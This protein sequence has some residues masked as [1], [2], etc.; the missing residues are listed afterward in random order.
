MHPSDTDSAPDIRSHLSAARLPAMPQVLLQLVDHCQ[1]DEMS[2]AEVAELVAKDVALTAKIFDLANNSSSSHRTNQPASLQQ[3]LN[4]LG[5]DMVRTLLIRESIAQVFD[6]PS[7]SNDID[8][9]GFWKHS[10]TA[11][12]AA[13][14]IAAKMGYPH[15]EE[16]YIAG[17]LHDVGRLALLMTDPKE[18]MSNIPAGDDENLCAAERRTLHITHPQA[19]ACLVARWELDSFLADSVLY[20]HE[21]VNR[22]E[23]A[24]PLIRIGFLAHQLSG[25]E[26][27]ARALEALGSLCGI[28]SAVL[29]LIRGRA[30][31]R[32]EKAAVRLGIDLAG[33]D[34]MLA[35]ATR[36]A[37][38]R[39]PAR[40]R[41]S[42]K[43][44]DL[45]VASEA[46][47]S[48]ARQEG[49]P[50]LLETVTQSA[51]LL[52]D[53]EDASLFL[54]DN[55]GHALIG[56]PVGP[57]RRRLAEFSIPL[58]GGGTIAAAAQQARLSYISHDD[59][60]LGVAEEQLLRILGTEHLV[61]VPL[62][63]AGR[64]HGVVIGGVSSSQL[65]AL[66]QREGF[67][68]AFGT[69]VA[70][71]LKTV[72]SQRDE[73]SRE[74]TE[75]K[76]KYREAARRAAHEANN[77]LSI[78]KNYLSVL[79]RKLAKQEPIS[80]EISILNE[81]INRVGQIINKLGDLQPAAREGTTEVNRVVNE[82]VR[83]FR[84]TEY[85]PP[86]VR[87]MARTQDQPLVV[88]GDADLLKQ[89]LVNLMKN[90]VEAL[91]GAGEIAIGT[92]GLVNR[93]GLLYV[94]LWIKD[95]GPGISP[96]VMANLFF[97]TRSTKGEGHR[98]I[99]LSIVHGLVKQL[100]GFITCRSDKNGTSF[101]ILLP[102][103]AGP[104]PAARPHFRNP[105]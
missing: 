36:P 23:K 95:T 31:V 44:R 25:E 52:F 33:T 65:P 104:S 100:Q 78:I 97:P 27:D 40:E 14:M 54:I 55:K 32:V 103:G 19:G 62:V 86:A 29:A 13:Q 30:A 101:E 45:V 61:C 35:P 84:D 26:Q 8:L 69:Q 96:D 42:A 38:T 87:I 47:R 93:D 53:F 17:L 94:E 43:V 21:P 102:S 12:V 10:L 50:K 85:I 77:P 3:A 80:G 7:Q 89:I 2:M 79:D 56:A 76:E 4:A 1:A 64:C 18:Y 105:V 90:A 70:T 68:Q 58:D 9:R 39:D 51:L 24:H 66:W 57:H 75:L 60:S 67:L 11:A 72:S 92:N 83:L 34:R 98:G 28:G 48:F 22:L 37:L 73:T 5:A 91:T 59:N 16:A 49:E 74:I 71:A 20:H 46:G 81:E 41:L 82:V 63:A 6:S 99:G 88:D 15:I